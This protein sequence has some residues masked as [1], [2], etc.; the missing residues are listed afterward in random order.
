MLSAVHEGEAGAGDQVARRCA[1]EHLAGRGQGGDKRSEVDRD[2]PHDAVD[3]LHLARVDS[4]ADA[5]P[6]VREALVDRMSAADRAG[7]PV[8]EGEDAVADGVD[9]LAAVS[10]ELEAHELELALQEIRPRPVAETRGGRRG[11]DDVGDHHGD[12]DAFVDDPGSGR[13]IAGDLPHEGLDDVEDLVRV[14]RDE[15]VVARELD[16][17]RSRDALCDVAA[18]VDP[19]GAVTGAVE[20]ERGDVDRSEQV[21]DV[22]QGVHLEQGSNRARACGGSA[23]LAPPPCH[24]VVGG[25]AHDPHVRLEAPVPGE[26]LDPGGALLRRPRPRVVL[27]GQR[28]LRVGPEEHEPRDALRM[29]PGVED[30]QRA[31]LRVPEQD[32]PPAF[33][34]FL[35]GAQVVHAG[36]EIRDARRPVG[37][38]GAALVEA[39]Q[40]RE[41]AESLEERSVA[42]LLPVLFEMGDEPGDEE[43]VD[44]SVA[45]HLIGDA[46]LAA[47]RVA[48]GWETL[49][50]RRPGE[51]RERLDA[52][53]GEKRTRGHEIRRA[54]TL[55]EP[56]DNLGDDARVV[57]SA[58]APREAGGRAEPERGRVARLRELER[59]P[60]ALHALGAL[61]QLAA[62]AEE[63]GGEKE[64]PRGCEVAGLVERGEG[65]VP[66]AVSPC[67]VGEDG[68]VERV[69]HAGAEA[70]GEVDALADLGE[71][72]VRV[73]PGGACPSVEDA[74]HRAPVR[75][76]QL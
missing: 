53:L 20:D 49:R 30:R 7:R 60:Q 13:E 66:P 19:H 74:R 37:E 38:A 32:R 57:E 42:G 14:D 21:T 75:E 44:H 73:V 64:R 67:R 27:V 69:V 43:H 28:A 23:A 68:Q 45:G 10:G 62:E 1:D 16:E 58:C 29:R 17:P 25:R 6:E 18:L 52:E 39:D 2:P 50:P 4:H 40:P 55:D 31:A 71:A 70:T 26:N 33:C 22:D 24:R 54:V 8:E 36:L 34:G 61:E 51:G 46:Q 11:V 59:L 12:Q 3:A 5:K 47:S 35:D 15:V 56:A 63:L 41:R 76:A 48:D 65:G 9:L 72:A